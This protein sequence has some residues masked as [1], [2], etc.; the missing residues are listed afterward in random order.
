MRN[1]L[2]LFLLLAIGLARWSALAHRAPAAVYD[3]RTRPALKVVVDTEE[4]P[5]LAEWAAEARALVQKWHPMVARMLATDGYFPPNQV[6]IVFKKDMKGVAYT[7][8]KTIIIAADWVSK[9]PDDFG[10]VVHELTHVIQS[11]PQYRP[12]WLVE[13]IADYVRFFHFEPKTRI[14]IDPRRASYKDG[15]RTTAKFLAWVEKTHDRHI[16][17]KLNEALRN[18]EYTDG[19]WRE[20]TSRTLDGLWAAFVAA[21]DRK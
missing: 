10:M 8:G 4:T 12:P 19:L 17:E 6:R 15:Y 3:E 21:E 5:D 18:G 1:R 16:I 2:V 7:Q 13:G 14:T 20:R 9:H 11:Y